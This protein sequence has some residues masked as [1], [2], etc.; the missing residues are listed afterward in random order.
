LAFFETGLSKPGL[1]QGSNDKIQ[2]SNQIQNPNVKMFSK[3]ISYLS[4]TL[5]VGFT[6]QGSGL[7]QFS[8]VN[9]YGVV[10]SPNLCF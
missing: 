10:I 9:L 1:G 5:V 7:F 2:M 4:V 3:T 6:V 8:S